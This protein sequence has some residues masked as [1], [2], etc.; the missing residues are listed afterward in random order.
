MAPTDLAPEGVGIL[1]GPGLQPRTGPGLIRRTYA[2][3]G[4]GFSAPAFVVIAAFTIF[5]IVF[6]VVLSF[7]KVNVTSNGFSLNGATIS[8]Y[9]TVVTAGL[10]HH[11]LWWTTVYTVVTVTA[12]LALGTVFALVLRRLTAGRGLMMALLLIPWSLITVISAELWSYIYNPTYGVLQYLW[13]LVTG[14][15]A[16]QFLGY[17]LDATISLMVADIWK[18][19]PFVTI[20]VLAGLVMIPTDLFEAADVDGASSWKTFW[21]VTLPLL[22]PTIGIA[23]LFRV[24]QA[25]G[26]F[27]LPYVLTNGGPGTSTQSLAILSYNTMFTDIDFGPGAAVAVSTAVIVLIMC[28]VFLRAF[29]QQVGK[30]EISA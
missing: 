22:R 4:W 7:E 3:L 19:T 11:A 5:P 26:L 30:E 8:N 27:D 16:P 6:A 17:P 21:R 28:L 10:W 12:E 23:V 18:T 25:F 29:K 24:L 1:K 13:H 2:R 20:I 9:R 15:A 14:G